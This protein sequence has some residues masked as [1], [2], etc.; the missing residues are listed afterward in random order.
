VKLFI[1]MLDG[2]ALLPVD[3][4][5]AGMQYTVRNFHV[6]TDKRSVEK[7]IVFLRA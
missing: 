1:G 4:V 5:A 2:L 6:L 3:D 7:Y